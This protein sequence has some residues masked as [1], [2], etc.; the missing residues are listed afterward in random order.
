MG[1][2]FWNYPIAFPPAPPRA[3]WFFYQ[4]PPGDLPLAL[5]VA[6]W[7]CWKAATLDTGRARA[8]ALVP[9]APLVVPLL[10]Q[11]RLYRG[12]W[13]PIQW[14]VGAAEAPVHAPM[15]A[16]HD[17]EMVWGQHTSRFR[18]DERVVLADAPS[19]RGPLCAVLWMDNQY[20][21]VTP[22]G[23]LGWGLL[24][25]EAPQWLEIAGLEVAHAQE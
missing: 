1:F 10:N 4:A 18:V 24:D 21:I 3:L 13:P 25:L 7:G 2:G 11:Q 17:Y 14:A 19:P 5:G 23:R 15:D 20:L 16:W 8:L 22:Q 9:F 6:G 12:L